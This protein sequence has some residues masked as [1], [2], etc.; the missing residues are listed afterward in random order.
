MATASAGSSGS[1]QPRRL[2]PDLPLVPCGK[3]KKN[4]MEEYRVR[5]LGA[6]NGRIFYTC[7]DRNVSCLFCHVTYFMSW[8]H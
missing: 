6:N 8:S 5:K 7:P 1:R 2:R 3:W 4:T